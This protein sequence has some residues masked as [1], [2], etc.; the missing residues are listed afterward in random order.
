[1]S[2]SHTPVSR[3]QRRAQERARRKS[4]ASGAA[5]TL[6]AAA[7]AAVPSA[8]AATFTVSNL[9][10][11]GPDS[12]RQAI[13]DANAAAGADVIDFQAGL[14]G[15]IVLTSGELDIT[16]SV[17]IQ[18][19]GSAAL[20]V[21]GNNASRVFYLY[22]GSALI[23]VTISGLTV[24]DGNA[25]I[26]GGIVDFDEN[27]TLD[28]V[29][30]TNSD[31][32]TDGGGL[33]ADG[34]NMTLTIRD[35]VFSGNSAGDDG[36]AIYI[37]DTGGLLLIQNTR[38]TGNDAAQ[39]GG[40]IYF[41]DPDEDVTIEDSTIS[42]NTAGT[43]GGG[44]YLYSPDNGTFTIRRTTISGNS[45]Q[46]GGGL[47]LYA[48]DHP[49][50]I[51]NSTIS[52]NS[53]TAG[54]GG[55]IYLYNLYDGTMVIRSSTI[56]SNTASG[57]G[58][59]IF[60]L[61]GSVDIENTI[62]GDNTAP[63]NNDLCGGAQFDLS[64]SL[65]ESPGTA[66]INDLGGSVLSQDPQLGPLQ[67]NGGPTE[68]H[69]PAVS[70]PAFNAGDPAFV[71]PPSTDQRGLPRVANGRL[72]MGSV[73]VAQLVAGT[74][75]LTVT[76][77]TVDE[78]VVTVTL[79]ATRSIGSDGAVSVDFGTADGT[80]VAPADYLAAMGTLNWADGDTAPKM[81]QVTIVDDIL[82]EASETFTVTLSNPQG[83]AALGANTTATVT[84]QDNDQVSVVE[85]P[86][87]DDVGKMLLMGV[88]G[89]AGLF[90]LRRRQGVAASA[91]IL[92]LAASQVEAA[93]APKPGRPQKEQK[94][95]ALT[96]IERSGETVILRLSDGSSLQLSL[97]EL[98]V[99][100][101]RSL[102]GAVQGVESLRAG[103]P[104]VVKVRRD[105][106]GSVKKVKLRVYETLEQARAAAIK[107][108]K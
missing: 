24:T 11:S 13:L 102:A 67:N 59:G 61:Y 3:R 26:G 5:L 68:T 71:P 45:A 55:G 30:V 35:S 17:D 90:L 95:V 74:I 76:A 64:Y 9:G 52:G 103:Q 80:A 36:G 25:S 21:S 83:G 58:G 50:I 41:Y 48:P 42:G 69:L 14:T 32:S 65:V 106:D 78:N 85:V 18:G 104:M 19:P 47:F 101:R 40:G 105:R 82:I 51:E 92:S 6:G 57:S 84:I 75:E 73:E 12:L 1:M 87:V 34:F 79:T 63:I 60:G 4:R 29:A 23:D 38:I 39:A 88:I 49:F 27:L 94:A 72:D 10:D 2:E 56:A 91:L 15:T 54:N 98:E 96:A 89:L 108:A 28:D 70:S 37:E 16:D 43:I 100:G 97:A 53:A 33:W 7:L 44:I 46:A 81:I 20:A 107:E 22:N 86:T 62:V 77:V 8:Q 66:N 31:A 99:Q 93:T